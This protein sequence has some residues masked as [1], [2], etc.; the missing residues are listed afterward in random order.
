[1]LALF[2]I[3]GAERFW[4]WMRGGVLVSILSMGAPLH[5]D[6]H[7]PIGLPSTPLLPTGSSTRLVPMLMTILYLFLASWF[8]KRAVRKGIVR[9]AP[10]TAAM[11]AAVSAATS[12]TLVALVA[13]LVAISIPSGMDLHI[14]PWEAAAW[15]ALVTA[16][17]TGVGAYLEAPR[18]TWFTAAVRGGLA[19]YSL[20]LG[21]ALVV[22]LVVAALEPTF[23]ERFRFVPDLLGGNVTALLAGYH[24]LAAPG[25]LAAA[26]VPATGSCLQIHVEVIVAAEAG[27]LCP[28]EIHPSGTLGNALLLSRT[29]L[30]PALWLLNGASVL[31]AGIGGW[32]AARSSV[33]RR[34]ILS[35][36]VAGGVFGLAV[37]AIAAFASPLVLPLTILGHV[38]GI[39]PFSAQPSLEARTLIAF[40]G[41]TF[42]GMLGGW[43]GGRR[44]YEELE[45]PS[46]TSA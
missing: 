17:G 19:G 41:A 7:I 20:A 45:L 42:V 2:S 11:V 10:L 22:L 29:T 8:G 31:G 1:M 4:L 24:L 40:G 18:K 30:T 25:H 39:F 33:C 13:P 32:R 36:G 26:L 44:R 12:G 43:V 9:S 38:P 5:I 46:P 27:R 15:A 37:T 23:I 28:W 6:Q 3:S 34:A 35:G 21:F 16:I 14:D